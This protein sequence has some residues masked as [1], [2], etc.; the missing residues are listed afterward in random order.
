MNHVFNKSDGSENYADYEQ[1]RIPLYKK[2]GM[3]QDADGFIREL[4]RYLAAPPYELPAKVLPRGLGY[5]VQVIG[6]K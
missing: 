2:N 1:V 3:T 4:R 6:E 5:A